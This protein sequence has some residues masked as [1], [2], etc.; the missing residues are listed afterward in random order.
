MKRNNK[1]YTLVELI[2]IFAILAVMIGVTSLSL[3]YLFGTQA[4]ECAQKVST[5]LSETK[6]GSMSRFDEKMKLSYRIKDSHAAVK[7]DGYYAEN[8]VYSIDKDAV[9]YELT[10]PEIKKMGSGRVVITVELSNG[11]IF[12]LGQDQSI[13]ISFDRSSG[14]LDPIIKNDVQE[15]AYLSK[16][17]F[18]AGL[19]T[20]TI[21]MVPETGKHTLE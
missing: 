21:T 7:S 9:S 18:A 14:A 11:D 8:T 4:R 20:Y 10:D 15:N 17:T 1:G 2:V 12:E 3:S 13:T 6:T 19:R 16:L 5:L